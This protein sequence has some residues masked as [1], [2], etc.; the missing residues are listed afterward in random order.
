M[1]PYW[2]VIP[3]LF[4]HVSPLNLATVFRVSCLLLWHLTLYTLGLDL[5]GEQVPVLQSVSLKVI[6]KMASGVGGSKPSSKFQLKIILRVQAEKQNSGIR[7]Q[8]RI[9]GHL[10]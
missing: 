3:Q 2:E 10:L 4:S 7:Q 6:Q 5:T 9:Q 8:F 1:E